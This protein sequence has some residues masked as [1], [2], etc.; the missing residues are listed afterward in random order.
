MSIRIKKA[1]LR[2][3]A[4]K[5]SSHVFTN[6]GGN[7]AQTSGAGIVIKLR[8]N[9]RTREIHKNRSR[10]FQKKLGARM[11][12]GTIKGNPTLVP[13][14]DLVQDEEELNTLKRGMI[15]NSMVKIVQTAQQVR[16]Q[17]KHKK[18]QLRISGKVRSVETSVGSRQLRTLGGTLR[19]TRNAQNSVKD[20]KKLIYGLLQGPK[21]LQIKEQVKQKQAIASKTKGVQGYRAAS[22]QLNRKHLVHKG[23][24]R[25]QKYYNLKELIKD[26]EVQGNIR[27][28]MKVIDKLCQYSSDTGL[29]GSRS[30]NLHSQ[31]S[32]QTSRQGVLEFQSEPLN[33]NMVKQF[34]QNPL[35]KKRSNIQMPESQKFLSNENRPNYS[36]QIAT[37]IDL[38]PIQ[39]ERSIQP[40]A[41]VHFP[42]SRSGIGQSL[43]KRAKYNKFYRA[44]NDT[45]KKNVSLLKQIEQATVNKRRLAKHKTSKYQ[46]HPLDIFNS[47]ALQQS[48]SPG[49]GSFNYTNGQIFGSTLKDFIVPSSPEKQ[50]VKV[51]LRTSATK[52]TQKMFRTSDQTP[53]HRERQ[54]S[55][56]SRMWK[57][58]GK[59]LIIKKPNS[60]YRAK[61]QQFNSGETSLHKNSRS[62]VHFN[63]PTG[64]S[65]RKFSQKQSASFATSSPSQNLRRSIFELG[66]T[67]R[68]SKTLNPSHKTKKT[69][70][71]GYNL[72][73]RRINRPSSPV[74]IRRGLFSGKKSRPKATFDNWGKQIYQDTDCGGIGLD[75]YIS[76]EEKKSSPELSKTKNFKKKHVGQRLKKNRS[77]TKRLSKHNKPVLEATITSGVEKG[78]FSRNSRA[79]KCLNLDLKELES[80]EMGARL[81]NR[82]EE[83]TNERS[84]SSE[85]ETSLS[86][87]LG[88]SSSSGL[89]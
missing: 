19:Q 37:R 23:S 48:S 67:S 24:K 77:M 20:T 41:R 4:L 80:P 27:S 16:K 88:S 52:N 70:Q 26:S 35:E 81:T 65:Y 74:F 15:A 82:V 51:Q 85:T 60:K 43:T 28:Q 2:T 3:K 54:F 40:V 78:I 50:S 83:S 84:Q 36:P 87:E 47:Q 89:G 7:S 64:S 55:N 39:A 29:I 69:V 1:N 14:Q 75:E 57:F 66:E 71:N 68:I 6:Q 25:Q 53:F 42:I 76:I 33:L 58:K 8:S 44:Q 63:F 30:L 79:E 62:G 45:K 46:N 31:Q 34:P 21:I 5:N 38:Q 11:K 72:N 61:Y 13:L 59:E 32:G 73:G 18:H 17:A 9:P 22:K 49:H 56:T 10:N 12:K 86:E